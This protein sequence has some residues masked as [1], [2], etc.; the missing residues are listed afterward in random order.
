[1]SALI[2]SYTPEQINDAKIILEAYAKIPEE[3][4]PIFAA[5]MNAFISGMETQER[6]SGGEKITA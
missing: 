4:K 6:L 2:N 3:K 1:M 5:M